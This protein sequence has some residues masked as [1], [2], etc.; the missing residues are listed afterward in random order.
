MPKLSLESIKSLLWI[1]FDALESMIQKV[2]SFE[3]TFPK[4]K[5]ALISKASLEFGSL[6][7][8]IQNGLLGIVIIVNGL[9][10]DDRC[11][12]I[13]LSSSIQ[14]SQQHNKYY[15]E[16]HAENERKGC[17]YDDGTLKLNSTCSSMSS[18]TPTPS[19]T[20][21]TCSIEPTELLRFILSLLLHLPIFLFSSEGFLKQPEDQREGS[22]LTAQLFDIISTAISTPATLR[23]TE[24]PPIFSPNACDEDTFR[25]AQDIQLKISVFHFVLSLLS[26]GIV[27]LPSQD[28]EEFTTFNSSIDLCTSTAD[29]FQV[30]SILSTMT[31][32][33]RFQPLANPIR[34]TSATTHKY[35]YTL[36]S[37]FCGCVDAF[38]IQFQRGRPQQTSHDTSKPTRPLRSAPP[39]RRRR[40]CEEGTVRLPLTFLH[41]KPTIDPSLFPTKPGELSD[42]ANGVPLRPSTVAGTRRP[43]RNRTPKR[44]TRKAVNRPLSAVPPGS[45]QVRAC[46]VQLERTYSPLLFPTS[47]TLSSHLS[48]LSPPPYSISPS[49]SPSRLPSPFPAIS[50]SPSPRHSYSQP[51]SAKGSPSLNSSFSAPTSPSLTPSLI[52]T[53]APKPLPM[54]EQPTTDMVSFSLEISDGQLHECAITLLIIPQIKQDASQSACVLT[55]KSFR[56]MKESSFA[57]NISTQ[58]LEQTT[59]S[60]KSTSSL[61]EYRP[62]PSVSMKQVEALRSPSVA[63]RV[64]SAVP[65]ELPFQPSKSSFVTTVKPKSASQ[66]RASGWKAAARLKEEADRV[67]ANRKEKN[68][69]EDALRREGIF[70]QGWLV[71]GGKARLPDEEDETNGK[72]RKAKRTRISD[73]TI[74]VNPACPVIRS[75]LMKNREKIDVTLKFGKGLSKSESRKSGIRSSDERDDAFDR[76]IGEKSPPAKQVMDEMNGEERKS[77]EYLSGSACAD[78]TSEE[79]KWMLVSRVDLLLLVEGDDFPSP[80]NADISIDPLSTF[81]LTLTPKLPKEKKDRHPSSAVNASGRKKKISFSN[82]QK[83][84][85][86]KSASSITSASTQTEKGANSF[87][88]RSTASPSIYFNRRIRPNTSSIH[89]VS[90]TSISGCGSRSDLRSSLPNPPVAPTH[91]KF[92]RNKQKTSTNVESELVSE[93]NPSRYN[94]T[95]EAP[96][97][98]GLIESVTSLPSFVPTAKSN[99]IRA[100]SELGKKDNA[101]DFAAN[102]KHL[103]F[104]KDFSQNAKLKQANQHFP[105]NAANPQTP[106]ST[107]TT[108]RL[109]RKSSSHSIISH[110]SHSQQHT[111]TTFSLHQPEFSRHNT[112]LVHPMLRGSF[113]THASSPSHPSLPPTLNPAWSEES[114]EAAA[115]VAPPFATPETHNGQMQNRSSLHWIYGT[116]RTI[117]KKSSIQKVK[118]ENVKEKLSKRISTPNLTP[119]STYSTL[120]P[121]SDETSK[122]LSSRASSASS[123]HKGGA[124][125]LFA[126]KEQQKRLQTLNREP[127]PSLTDATRVSL[128]PFRQVDMFSDDMLYLI[129]DDELSDDDGTE[130]SN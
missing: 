51:D 91:F 74:D 34:G 42:Y 8:T 4:D 93:A 120:S 65:Q 130:K 18:S 129:S 79:A 106:P 114:K 108:S 35:E 97:F 6:C 47:P 71:S 41:G 109:P 81:T 122:L 20:P 37:L 119:S 54:F 30:I 72:G 85:H 128:L 58:T 124:F 13:I 14:K 98:Y 90:R 104:Q 33:F 24:V 76:A 66:E 57:S 116:N 125:T 75:F 21:P 105:A 19:S 102:E 110:H 39:R 92:H 67:A 95:E 103:H 7:A 26:A 89:R 62:S 84:I 29:G 28:S 27:S 83:N 32:P 52:A 12:P 38:S 127:V 44:S 61:I 31:L 86:Q 55:E 16:A 87:L 22:M 25:G 50:V 56:S 77:N 118:D 1:C 107:P 59:L 43:K 70:D 101:F 49:L 45:T 68:E 2:I 113:T 23:L 80:E 82:F 78:E 3:S 100:L 48:S 99:E 40:I 53:P 73:L 123:I 64:L 94:Q 5:C 117:G 115:F 46:S 96:Q 17:R 9:Y 10:C 69:K 126:L 112:L 63:E 121:I 15:A 60:D 88:R 111:S 36:H 11:L